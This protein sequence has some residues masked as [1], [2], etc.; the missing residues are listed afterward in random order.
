M[1]QGGL[2][3]LDLNDVPIDTNEDVGYVPPNYFTQLMG[4]SIDES[5]PA[6]NNAPPNNVEAPVFPH[7]DAATNTDTGVCE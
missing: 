3:I 2:H 4:E 7:Q 5:Q 6:P 1:L